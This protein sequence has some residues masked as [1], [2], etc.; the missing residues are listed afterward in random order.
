MEQDH[1]W[2]N[3]SSEDVELQPAGHGS[4]A[5]HPASFT[6]G[7]ERFSG[8]HEQ[9]ANNSNRMTIKFAGGWDLAGG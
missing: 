5:C 6:Q 3:N 9:E 8:K 7:I 2:T 1:E 4:P